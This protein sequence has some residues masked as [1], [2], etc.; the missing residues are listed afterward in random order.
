MI[1]HQDFTH[2]LLT[3]FNTAIQ[4]VGVPSA[5][6]SR[7]L[8]ETWLRQ[9]LIL[10]EQYCLPSVRAQRD[11]TFTWLVFC[12]AKSPE[13]FRA[14]MRAY[15]S[16]LTPVYI[17]GPATDDAIVASIVQLDLVRA[18]WLITTRLDNDDAIGDRHLA[19]V[20]GA[21]H[22]QERE[23]VEFP[24]GLQS[25]RGQLYNVYWPSNPFL[26]LIEKV[27][28]SQ[29][30]TT[31]LCVHHNKVRSAGKVLSLRTSPQWLQVI[32][33]SGLLNSLRGWPRLSNTTPAHF[34][35]QWPTE[36]AKDSFLSRVRF[37]AGAFLERGR[38][39]LHRRMTQLR[40][41]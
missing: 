39:V 38:K 29:S 36:V 7:G 3:R 25:F 31:I 18:P 24:F 22:H 5:S 28:P 26:S 10:F 41:A 13:W 16:A 17:D 6:A 2:L 33:G 8:D 21:F 27:Q 34:A 9:R 37:S 19:L 23:F 35:V 1:A 15:G 14:R 12:D 32:H 20:Q 4:Y 30:F 40:S 11:V